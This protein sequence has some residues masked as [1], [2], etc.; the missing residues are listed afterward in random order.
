MT[1]KTGEIIMKLLIIEDE[2]D[3]LE[4]IGEGLRISG[5]YVDLCDNGK[6]GLEMALFEAYDLILLDLNLPDMDGLEI[7]RELRSHKVE[8]Q[9]L[10]LTARSSISDRV[11]GLDLGADDY[12]TKP[13]AF[14]ELEARVR[15]LLR[16]QH[17]SKSTELSFSSLKFD[18]LSRTL[19]VK[20]T[21]VSLT[22]KE[23][24]IIE[25]LLLHKDRIISSEELIEH[26]WDSNTD[27]F[28]NSIRVHLSSLRKK[29]KA[30]LGFDPIVN[31]VGEGYFL[32]EKEDSHV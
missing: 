2:K 16:R 30:E 17:K 23:T 19:Y 10:I 8:S 22:K 11:E 9:V 15:S 32:A 26:A 7:L 14:P 24:A 12:L 31:K 4:A 20:D 13:F 18:T 3:L 1:A 27:P 21:I 25:Y 29:I 28:S 6:Y 5:Y